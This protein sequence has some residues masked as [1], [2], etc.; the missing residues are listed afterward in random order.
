ML[1][2]I[3]VELKPNNKQVTAFRKASGVA[4]HAYNWANALVK[5][6]LVQRET[7]KTIKVPSAI[8][9]HKRL[10]AEVK[11]ENAWYYETNKNVPQQALKELRT[12]WDRCFKKVAKQP[13]FKKKGQRDS[14][15]LES[16]SKAA[17]KIKNDGQRIKLPSIGWV[18]LAE[19]LPV[20]ATHNCVISRTA[21]KW[22]I[23]I[24]YEVEKPSIE[25]Q[26]PTVGVDIGIKELAVCSNGKV[27][28]NPK[29]YRRMSKRL[30]HLQRQV[31]KKVKGSNNRKKAVTKLAKIHARIA[32]IRKDAIHK[33]TTYLAKNHSIIKI[34]DLHVKAFLKNH[35]LAG[36][37]ADC[38]MYE[39][40]R[41]L[42][43]KTEKF[44][45]QLILV[46]RMFP[47][48]QICSNCGLHRHKMPLKNR[49]YIC[50]D[51][52][53]IEDRDLNASK[54]IERWFEGISIPTL[55]SQTVSST[56][57]AC[58][59]D[60]PFSCQT[61]ATLKQEVNAKTTYV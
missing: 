51:C 13:K 47:S 36:A 22:F 14:F 4:R 34:E 2:S 8:D 31:S 1:L 16:G 61:K 26:R 28:K 55:P 6:V 29:T 12:A 50:P 10:V 43:Y 59:V 15:Y 33:L 32:N 45:S 9:L 38:G 46:D 58:G 17:P 35:R 19:P 44:S 54:N 49:V 23:A 21:D 53:H 52:G 42:E 60:K 57:M 20:T 24:K 48:S 39:F 37:I 11:S 5:D 56:G 3:K 40:R 7:D 27:F 25:G 18:R 30:K 41:Q